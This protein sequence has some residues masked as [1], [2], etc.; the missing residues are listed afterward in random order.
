[1]KNNNKSLKLIAILFCLVCISCNKD[2]LN[3]YPETSITKENFFNSEED[4][5]LYIYGLYNFS[6][7]EIYESDRSTD[8]AT[9]TGPTEIKTMMISEPNSVTISSGWDWTQ[10]RRINFFLENFKNDKVSEERL[11][12]YEGL[13][14][15]F[16]ARFYVGKVK[17]Y[18]DVPWVDK[19]VTTSDEITLFGA[20]DP[21]ATVVEKIMENFKYAAENVDVNAPLG[22]V[23]R[24]VVKSEWARYA[25]YEGSY[26]KYHDEL[27]L[28]STANDFLDIAAVVSKDIIDNGGFAI[29]STGKPEED[30]A[31]LFMSQN[32]SG[33][34]EVIHGRFYE[35]NVLNASDWPGMFGNYEYSPSKDLV[36]AYLMKDGSFYSEQPGYQTNSFVKEFENRDPRLKQSYAF[37]GWVLNYTSTYSQGGGVYIQQL[38]KNFTG[39]HQI[40]GFFNHRDQAL[41]YNIDVPLIRYAEILLIYAEAKAERG[42]ITQADLDLSVNQLRARTGMPLMNISTGTDQVML[43]SFPNVSGAFKELILEIRRE[44]RVELAFEGF[45]FDDLMRWKAGK[46]LENKIEGIYFSGLGKHDITGDGE[47]DI[48]LIEGSQSI[49]EVKEKNGLGVDLIYYRVGSFGQDVSVF[50]KNGTSGTIQTVDNAGT[51]NDPKYYYRPIPKSETDL[52]PELKQIFGWN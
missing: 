11:K 28:Q 51:F 35:T 27:N 3:K 13:A 47:P 18:S 6:G 49:P 36:Q 9:T 52:N 29:Y 45:R 30:Y 16:R 8:N 1:M 40:K 17:R 19:V 25:L 42:D 24:W 38:A 21:R 37:P 5:N 32:L 46:L 7:S 20:R 31:A 43:T 26:R 39:Y 14:R 50:L 12:H 10:L 4:L 2:F 34:R 22:A 44:R 33:N 41:R 48:Y 23:N 15:Y